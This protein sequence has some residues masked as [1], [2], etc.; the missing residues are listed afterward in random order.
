MDWLFL[1]VVHRGLTNGRTH[2][3]RYVLKDRSTNTELFVVVFQLVPTEEA[4]Q[5]GAKSPEEM[6]KE[7]HEKPVPGEDIDGDDDELD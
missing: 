5:A 4:H 1:F 3:L 7:T 2:S 6:F